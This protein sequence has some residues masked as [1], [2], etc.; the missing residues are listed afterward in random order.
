MFY[1]SKQDLDE[2]V[3]R[4]DYGNPYWIKQGPDGHCTHSDPVTRLCTIHEHRPFICRKFD[5]RDDKRIWLDFEKKI[6]APL[7]RA[8]GDDPV[9]EAEMLLHTLPA[10]DG[11]NWMDPDMR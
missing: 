10:E 9:G 8:P 5:C 1:L 2:G 11:P 3:V 6:P 7:G 4:W